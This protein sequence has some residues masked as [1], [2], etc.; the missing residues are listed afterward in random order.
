MMGPELPDRSPEELGQASG[1]E[2]FE[3]WDRTLHAPESKEA[4]AAF[5]SI[6]VGGVI[7]M[8]RA[9]YRMWGEPEACQVLFDPKRRRLE[10]KPVRA[11]ETKNSSELN[12]H[13][14][15]QIACKKLF[16]YYGISIGEAWRYHDLK[17]IDGVLVIDL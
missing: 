13:S 12:S 1:L 14:Q 5:A 4:D 9:A 10:L 7:G 6:R 2:R 11:G 16:D 17:V 15:V 8:N 3:V